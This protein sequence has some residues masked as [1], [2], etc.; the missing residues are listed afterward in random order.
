MTAYRMLPHTGTHRQGGRDY[1]G[2]ETVESEMDLATVFPLKFERVLVEPQQAQTDA[3]AM[4]TA[5]A[6]NGLTV[7]QRGAWFYV[8]GPDGP[9]ISGA[10]RKGA[11][12]DFVWDYVEESAS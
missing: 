5:A 1:N 4:F 6:D 8:C 3:T 2:G 9:E 7:Q 11:V 12:E 10:L